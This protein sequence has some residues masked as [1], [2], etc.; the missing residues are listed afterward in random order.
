MAEGMRRQWAAS[1]ATSLGW[2][3]LSAVARAT[4]LARNTIKVGLREL[5]HRAAHPNDPIPER[6]LTYHA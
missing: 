4:G 2:A 1:E 6:Q 5:D 3:G